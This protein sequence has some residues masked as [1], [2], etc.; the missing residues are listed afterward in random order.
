MASSCMRR[1]TNS[2]RLAFL[3]TLAVAG[4]A[5]LVSGDGRAAESPS[6]LPRAWAVGEIIDADIVTP[7]TLTVFHQEETAALR[8]VEL[9]K[10][11]SVWRHDPAV[12]DAVEADLRKRFMA[13][14]ERFGALIDR[15]FQQRPL[16]NVAALSDRRF[17]DVVKTFRAQETGFPLSTNLAELWALGDAGQVVLDDFVGQLKRFMSAHL[18]ADQPAEAGAA[19]APVW[20]ISLQP[21]GSGPGAKGSILEQATLYPASRYRRELADLAP[22]SDRAV[23]AFLAGLLRPN[24][25][26]DE[27]A[28]AQA[29]ARRQQELN[30]VDVHESGAVI[31]RRGE[32]VDARLKRT[33]DTLRGQLQAQTATGSAARL[34]IELER[35]RQEAGQLQSRLEADRRASSPV[36]APKINSSNSWVQPVGLA[37][38]ALALALAIGWW[39]WRRRSQGGEWSIVSAHLDG[40]QGAEAE[41]WRERAL[42]AEA[43]A[44]KAT[45]MLRA[46]MVPHLARWMMNELVQRLMH[47]RSV[48]QTSQQRAE[49]EVAE[50][51]E[52]L[53]KLQ[54]PLEERRRA[55]EQRIQQLE[56]QLAARDRQDHELIQ[57]RLDSTRRRLDSDRDDSPE[58]F[59]S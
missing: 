29:R 36:V 18:R 30:V 55:Y 35:A 8:A 45:A 38:T 14:R 46:R 51:A 59:A 24:C 40:V 13:A 2:T 33:L 4:V 19:A 53:E 3:L 39:R 22:A 1:L 32:R 50:L 7:F 37:A 9:P 34:Q 25:V 54:A 44:A 48:A 20:I 15:E 47:Q 49:Q 16:R 6:A 58:P 52:R 43:K 42:A 17:F 21:A 11:P 41:Q 26:L 57:A 56:A 28:T 23:V 10:V 27:Q 31:A 5:G 12:A